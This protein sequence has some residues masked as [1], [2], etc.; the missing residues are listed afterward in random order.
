[1]ADARTPFRT[2]SQQS[3][4]SGRDQANFIDISSASPSPSRHRQ[5]WSQELR[6]GLPALNSQ[7]HGSLNQQALQE[8]L[9][10][11]PPM[12]KA[13]TRFANRDWKHIQVKEVVDADEVHFAE[14]DTSV[15]E[16]TNVR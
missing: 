5:S 14:I 16:A 3:N 4:S 9:T 7:R 11:A 8:L 2:R 15:E 1:M 12:D 10:N 6:G 13:E